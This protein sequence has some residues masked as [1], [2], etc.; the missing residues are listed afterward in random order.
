MV[1]A[2]E[3]GETTPLNDGHY[4][5]QQFVSE[6]QLELKSDEIL[7]DDD[8]LLYRLLSPR[9]YQKIVPERGALYAELSRAI[10][11]G[12]NLLVMDFGT[13]LYSYYRGYGASIKP[14]MVKKKGAEYRNELESNLNKI[15]D[16]GLEVW[17]K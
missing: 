2:Q 13:N 10:A 8:S 14:E 17:L 4:A 15:Y 16:N 5:L 12:D 1:N 3:V 9:E 11:S 7:S 6:N